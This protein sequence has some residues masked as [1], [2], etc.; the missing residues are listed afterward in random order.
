M[1]GLHQQGCC[2]IE[3]VLGVYECLIGNVCV[4]AWG[5]GGGWQTDRLEVHLCQHD[6]RICPVREL[7]WWILSLLQEKSKSSGLLQSSMSRSSGFAKRFG[8]K[9]TSK[10]QASSDKLMI[11]QPTP[12]TT[13]HAILSASYHLHISSTRVLQIQKLSVC[14]GWGLPSLKNK[15]TELLKFSAANPTVG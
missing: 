15:Q 3:G 12:G 14:V 7:W 2:S 13:P 5:G 4:C 6:G 8:S 1:N 9:R 11:F 10:H